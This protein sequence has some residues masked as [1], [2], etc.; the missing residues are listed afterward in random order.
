[1]M[2]DERGKP[3]VISCAA[4]NVAAYA[5]INPWRCEQL[6][7]T[8][9]HAQHGFIEAS[10]TRQTPYSTPAHQPLEMRAVHEARAF[11]TGSAIKPTTALA[12]KILQKDFW[13]RGGAAEIITTSAPARLYAK[14]GVRRRSDPEESAAR[15][16]NAKHIRGKAALLN[17]KKF[18]KA[19]RMRVT[20]SHRQRVGRV[21]GAG[22]F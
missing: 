8:A 1:M 10:K 4:R 20:Q 7:F 9:Y 12:K 19:R 15:H 3:R 14:F 18:P 11:T 5:A 16:S 22:Y 13:R 2:S 6:F 17:S 21:V